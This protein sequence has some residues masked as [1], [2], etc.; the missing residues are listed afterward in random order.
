[1]GD[2]EALRRRVRLM[3]PPPDEAQLRQRYAVEAEAMGRGGAGTVARAAG[4]L[5][6]TAR[7][8][9]RDPGPGAPVVSVDRERKGAVGRFANGA[10]EGRPLR[11]PRRGGRR[12][13]GGRVPRHRPPRRRLPAVVVG[14]DGRRGVPRRRRAGRGLRRGR[15][16]RQ[17]RQAPGA[18]AAALLR[19]EAHG[20]GGRHLPPGTPGWSRAGYRPFAQ[21]TRNWRGRQAPGVA[22]GDRRPRRFDDDLGGPWSCARSARAR[23]RPGPGSPTRRRA[24]STSPGRTSTAS[25]TMS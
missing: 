3:R 19:P 8:R 1:M 9:V 16:Q 7:A 20:G 4:C 18:R 25:G 15:A 5:G 11:G 24:P 2:D 23:T 21:I 22:Q 13:L 6:S 10:R 17:L 14:P 12:G